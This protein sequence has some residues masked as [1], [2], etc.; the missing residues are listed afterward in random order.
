MIKITRN[1]LKELLLDA[2]MKGKK[3]YLCDEPTANF[4][5]EGIIIEYLEEQNENA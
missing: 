2:F 3:T 4:W 5:A 1:K